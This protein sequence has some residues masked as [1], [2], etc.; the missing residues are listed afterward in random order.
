MYNW[1]RRNNFHYHSSVH[2][3]AF[4]L[5]RFET[6]HY[7][8]KGLTS[9]FIGPWYQFVTIPVFVLRYLFHTINL[10]QAQDFKTGSFWRPSIPLPS[11]LDRSEAPP[12]VFSLKESFIFKS[13]HLIHRQRSSIEWIRLVREQVSENMSSSGFVWVLLK[14][15]VSWPMGAFV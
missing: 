13:L 4:I 3:H 8:L 9:F 5:Q 10:V 7:Q 14:V 1:W 15:C 6:S 11:A 12:D 2:P